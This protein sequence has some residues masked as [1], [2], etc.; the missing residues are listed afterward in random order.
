ME[1]RVKYEAANLEDYR[2][3]TR[4]RTARWRE[5]QRTAGN[6]L[7]SLTLSAEAYGRLKAEA[8]RSG[9]TLSAVAERILTALPDAEPTASGPGL[10]E[11]I[12]SM[13]AEGLSMAAIAE[14]FN[15]AG[16]PTPSG[17]G[18]W[19]KSTVNNVKRKARKG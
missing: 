9:E 3:A 2:R 18:I 12:E 1:D 19:K 15:A 10:L 11:R 16:T 8:E 6:K 13:T 4:R 14:R 7:V 5:R 17:R